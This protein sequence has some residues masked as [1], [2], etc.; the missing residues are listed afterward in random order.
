M[1]HFLAIVSSE[2]VLEPDYDISFSVVIWNMQ[3]LE[4]S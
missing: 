3:A 4:E 1:H 2:I